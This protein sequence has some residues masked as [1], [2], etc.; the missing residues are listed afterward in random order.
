MNVG[1]VFFGALGHHSV[2]QKSSRKTIWKHV[3]ENKGQK[4]RKTTRRSKAAKN[5]TDTATYRV[6]ANPQAHNTKSVC[7]GHMTLYLPFYEWFR[8]TITLCQSM[9]QLTYPNNTFVVTSQWD[10][11][12][13]HE[14]RQET[15]EWPG[16]KWFW[17][18]SFCHLKACGKT[19]HGIWWILKLDQH[20][21]G[22]TG[23]FWCC[24]NLLWH[25]GLR[26]LLFKT[27]F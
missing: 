24:G 14:H 20:K 8:I 6:N 27:S 17:Q 7:S 12:K 25:S 19:L 13:L 15:K 1:F 16:G 10:H 2:L 23:M 4:H 26:G 18:V 5:K 21:Y 22:N 11:G 9:G 3:P